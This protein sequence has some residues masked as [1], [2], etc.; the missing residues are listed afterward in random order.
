MNELRNLYFEWMAQVAISDSRTRDDY[1]MLLEHLDNMDFTYSIPMDE[2]RFNDGQDLRYR[3]GYEYNI[4]EEDI[5]AMSCEKGSCS[6]LEMMVALSLKIEEN[7]MSD[8]AYGNRI[9]N[10]F[11]EMLH[12][13]KLDGMTNDRYDKYW[14]DHRIYVLLNHIYDPNGSGGLFTIPDTKQDLRYVDIW[15]QMS[16]YINT[17]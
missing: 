4:P 17:I 1:L 5:D 2:N 6:I 7:F 12:S 10:W 14:I 8:P 9:S 16:W 15:N 3:F 13:L 11:F